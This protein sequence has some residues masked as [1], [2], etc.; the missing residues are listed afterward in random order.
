MISACKSEGKR[1]KIPMELDTLGRVAAAVLVM[2]SHKRFFK[3]TSTFLVSKFVL[4]SLPGYNMVL[5]L[6]RQIILDYP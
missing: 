1:H 6:L 3:S 4:F 2:L 5:I